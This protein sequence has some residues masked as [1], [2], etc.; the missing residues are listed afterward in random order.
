MN[1][2][3]LDMDEMG[4]FGEELHAGRVGKVVAAELHRSIEAKVIPVGWQ[5]VE[6]APREAASACSHIGAEAVKPASP[7][8]TL[9]DWRKTGSLAVST[10]AVGV[11]AYAVLK[12]AQFVLGPQQ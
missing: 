2:A 9:R 3:H 7:G 4:A 8:W 1:A 6:G 5:V 10:F 12:L 11:L